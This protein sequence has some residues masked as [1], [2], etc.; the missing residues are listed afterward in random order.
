ML[1]NFYY[2]SSLHLELFQKSQT[3]GLARPHFESTFVT[4]YVWFQRLGYPI[5]HFSDQEQQ[6]TN[7]RANTRT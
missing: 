3:R 6:N 1:F 5:I 2:L 7:T 4:P